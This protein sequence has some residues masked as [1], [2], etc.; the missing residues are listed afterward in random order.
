MTQSKKGGPRC[1]L[2]TGGASGFGLAIARALLDQGARVAIGD[3]HAGR[4]QEAVKTLD[5]DRVLP[6]KLDVTSLDSVRAAVAAF[7]AAASAIAPRARDFGFAAWPAPRPRASRLFL[8]SGM[9]S[10]TL[11]EASAS[12][13]SST[14]STSPVLTR[15]SMSAR[16]FS[17]KSSRYL[18]GL[19]SDAMPW[20]RRTAIASSLGLVVTALIFFRRTEA[21]SA[22]PHPSRTSRLP[23][24]SNVAGA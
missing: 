5:S 20:T 3:I 24:P 23:P 19:Q 4:L 2:V 6:L 10:T 1:A 11:P 14:S 22:E 16:I 9:R 8:R 17:V 15:R 21:A 13:G 7:F 18:A 12:A